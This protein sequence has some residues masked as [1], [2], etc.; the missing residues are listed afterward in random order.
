[1]LCRRPKEGK[2]VPVSVGEV[3]KVKG[4]AGLH[5]VTTL[6]G[7][8]ALLSPLFPAGATTFMVRAAPRVARARAH[9]P[10]IVTIA[11]I[12]HHNTAPAPMH[13]AHPSSAF[14]TPP[15]VLCGPACAPGYGAA[16]PEYGWQ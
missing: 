15:P 14:Q 9:T 8:T 7:S 12:P 6:I 3:V 1:M 5:T 2:G 11:P 4:Q 16:A 10:V 13:A